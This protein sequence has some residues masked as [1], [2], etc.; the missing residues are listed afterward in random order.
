MRILAII[1]FVC[2]CLVML[3]PLIIQCERKIEAYLKRR[4]AELRHDNDDE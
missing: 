4:Y 1:V 3:T 2:L